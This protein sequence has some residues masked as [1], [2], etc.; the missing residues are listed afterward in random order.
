[1]IS[2]PAIGTMA[3]GVET[4]IASGVL[5]MEIVSNNCS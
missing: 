2:P 1:M 5:G 4:V 3:R